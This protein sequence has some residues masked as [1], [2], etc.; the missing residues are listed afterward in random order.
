MPGLGAFAMMTSTHSPLGVRT[1][2]I[3]GAI[4]VD[5]DLR[6]LWCAGSAAPEIIAHD[7]AENEPR[8]AECALQRA[9]DL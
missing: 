8:R 1:V 5:A 7:Q 9:A 2:S 4:S 6:W 3:E